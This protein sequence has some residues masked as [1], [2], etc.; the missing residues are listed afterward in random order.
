MGHEFF[1]FGATSTESAA[2]DAEGDEGDVRAG[3]GQGVCTKPV[4]DRIGQTGNLL[5]LR[6]LPF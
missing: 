6:D 1:I 3:G 5:P 4:N 2:V